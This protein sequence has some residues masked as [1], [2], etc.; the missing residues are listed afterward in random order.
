MSI[1]KFLF[2]KIGLLY[3]LY[4][5]SSMITSVSDPVAVPPSLISF[6]IFDFRNLKMITTV[7]GSKYSVMATVL[8]SNKYS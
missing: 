2:V 3:R 6:L 7:K 4:S 5:P 1:K 8:L